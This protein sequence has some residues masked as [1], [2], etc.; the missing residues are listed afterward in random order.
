VTNAELLVRSYEARDEAGVTALWRESFPDDPP[1]NA[2]ELVIRRK[3]TVQP[4]LLLVGELAG[5]VVAAVVAGFDGFRGWINHL[6]V[7]PEHRRKGFGR[8]LVSEAE[9][10]LRSLG[11][12]KVNLQVR[13]SNAGVAD[14]YRRLGYQVEERISFGKSLG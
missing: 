2:P 6:A 7:A 11:C 10:R 1:R 8:A 4:E 14:F 9:T 3:L 5:A 12:P 13:P